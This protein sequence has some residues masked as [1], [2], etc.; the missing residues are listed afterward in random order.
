MPK[1]K[2]SAEPKA[3]AGNADVKSDKGEKA[4]LEPEVRGSS[5]DQSPSGISDIYVAPT[6]N[7]VIDGK[8]PEVGA[9]KKPSREVVPEE[10][11]AALE[12]VRPD[13]DLFETRKSIR[14]AQAKG[15]WLFEL[16]CCCYEAKTEFDLTDPAFPSEQLLAAKEESG[17]CCR[18]L[19]PK[20]HAWHMH[21]TYPD[22]PDKV[23][24]RVPPGK[25]EAGTTIEYKLG[26]RRVQLDV[27][28]SAK[29][30]EW[31][32]IAIPTS[33]V[34][35]GKSAGAPVARFSRPLRCGPGPCKPCCLQSMS[36][37]AG[38]APGGE[39]IGYF[40]EKSC[41]CCVPTYVIAD[42]NKMP[43]YLLRQPTCLCG[44][45][46]DCFTEK[47]C[48]CRVPFMIYSDEQPDQVVGKIV[49]IWAGVEK[50]LLTDADTFICEFPD[51][52][53]AELKT[54]LVGATFMINQ[55]YFE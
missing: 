37:F 41:Y 48:S 18:A 25:I 46:V 11:Q 8:A 17:L 16:L 42:R 35:D 24:V 50:E 15:N 10:S 23:R 44:L 53:D 5:L 19:C 52:A 2:K 34:L 49:K 4:L 14:V 26:T 43:K 51:D 27:P 31:I 55:L 38:A 9:A 12:M 40:D 54:T 3:P 39:A 13:L 29:G 20:T 6:A 22:Q 7:D 1:K 36:T 45:C 30:G 21:M 33:P 28:P 32:D 47:C